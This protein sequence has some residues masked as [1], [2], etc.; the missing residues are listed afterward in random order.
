MVD[1]KKPAYHSLNMGKSFDFKKTSPLAKIKVNKMFSPRETIINY[2]TNYSKETSVRNNIE[3]DEKPRVFTEEDDI[4]NTLSLTD[5][6]NKM[7]LSAGGPRTK[8]S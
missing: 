2:K 6:F 4:T 5:G 7:V 8:E 1:T 3:F